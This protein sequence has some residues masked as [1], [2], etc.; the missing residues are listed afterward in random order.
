LL[1]VRIE[2]I[3]LQQLVSIV[4]KLEGAMFVRTTNELSNGTDSSAMV[5]RRQVARRG[6][7]ERRA[8]HLDRSSI[9]MRWL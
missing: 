6:L 9:C 3:E 4:K 1:K 8:A 7:I 5:R 2:P